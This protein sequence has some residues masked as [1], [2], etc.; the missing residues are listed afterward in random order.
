MGWRN[1]P[2]KVDELSSD[3]DYVMFIDESGSSEMKSIAKKVLS[4]K[5]ITDDEKCFIVTGVL[6]HKDQL[7]VI[8]DKIVKLKCKFW[9][10]H[11][12][13]DYKGVEKRVCFHSYELR[14]RKGVFGSHILS[15]RE[16]FL[17]ELTDFLKN[18]DVK[19]FSFAIDKERLYR[20]YSTPDHPYDLCMEFLLERFYYSIP[21]GAKGVIVLEGRGKKDDKD[22]LKQIV[23]MLDN[24][25]RFVIPNQLSFIKG[26]YF[27][28][29]WSQNHDCKKTYFGLEIADLFS[30]PLYVY[31]KTGEKNLPF[32]ILE[33]K[34]YSYPRYHGKGYKK[35]P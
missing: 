11:G 5:Q 27:N 4:G 25:T 6:I 2:N 24:G 20:K 30:H 22:L 3:I 10:P 14:K 8:A 21:Q 31:A 15:N 1:R 9:P 16:A 34:L 33:P 18:L 35:F 26:V 7:Q 19:I 12:M 28:D 17:L 13:A 23:R 32:G 29:K